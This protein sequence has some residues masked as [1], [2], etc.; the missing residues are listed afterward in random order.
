MQSG[1]VAAKCRGLVMAGLRL[2]A[3]MVTPASAVHLVHEMTTFG[4]LEPSG[5]GH[6]VHKVPGGA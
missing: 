2:K 4:A 3:Q 6:L 5:C 1:G